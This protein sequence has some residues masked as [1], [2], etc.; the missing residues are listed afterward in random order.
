[1]V[2]NSAGAGVAF[3]DSAESIATMNEVTGAGYCMAQVR[4]VNNVIQSNKCNGGLGLKLINSTGL[5]SDMLA[6][7]NSNLDQPGSKNGDMAATGVAGLIVAV[8]LL[9]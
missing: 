4:T 5:Q 6:N 1:V 7:P 3:V 2:V 9:L 8:L